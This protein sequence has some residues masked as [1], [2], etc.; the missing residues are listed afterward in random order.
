M[1]HLLLIRHAKSS[2]KNKILT[3]V[4][5]P[6]NNRGK[7]EGKI[8]GRLLK[9]NKLLPDLIISSHAKRARKTAKKIAKEIKYPKNNLKI[10]EI[11]YQEDVTKIV[12]LLQ[13]MDDDLNQIFIVGHNPT[14][15]NLTQYFTN[16]SL[17][18]FATSGFVLISFPIKNWHDLSK[19]IG[20]ISKKS[21][22]S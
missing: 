7:K 16:I 10:N 12:N 6:L 15:M 2:W 14:L 8:L 18:K 20:N 19:N 22:A 21:R 5:R 17:K 9:K 3:D 11:I 1:K 13:S 4:E